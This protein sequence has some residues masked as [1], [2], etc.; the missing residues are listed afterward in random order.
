MIL[1]VFDYCDVTWHNSGKGNSDILESLQRRACRIVCRD[2]VCG[3]LSSDLLLQR[4]GWELL[5]VRREKHVLKLVQKCI[6]GNVPEYFKNYFTKR[7][8]N[9][10]D[11]LTR[12]RSL[13]YQ[14]R[15]KLEHTKL[16]FFY[17]GTTIF[18]RDCSS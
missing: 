17:K 18:N 11:H 13:L 5:H 8:M 14:E 4:L 7:H 9:V 3:E 12:Y 6:N 16:A 15:I 1:S 10:H 2:T